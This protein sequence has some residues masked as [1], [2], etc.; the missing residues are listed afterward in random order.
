MKKISGRPNIFELATKE[1]TLDA[2]VAWL[3]KSSQSDRKPYQTMG[4]DFI[5]TFL[6]DG[7]VDGNDMELMDCRLQ[8]N[9]IDVFAVVR[10]GNVFHPVIFEDKTNTS[11][12]AGDSI[13]AGQMVSY[14]KKVLGWVETE[15][16]RKNEADGSDVLRQIA[17]NIEV[18][19]ADSVWGE[20]YYVYFKIGFIHSKDKQEYEAQ[21]EYLEKYKKYKSAIVFPEIRTLEMMHDFLKRHASRMTDDLLFKDY[22]AYVKKLFNEM[23]VSRTNWDADNPTKRKD[24]LH[25]YPGQHMVFEAAFGE[26]MVET[27]PGVP[28]GGLQQ[29]GHEVGLPRSMYFGGRVVTGK[30]KLHYIFTFKYL[31]REHKEYPVVSF[32]QYRDDSKYKAPDKDRIQEYLAVK[33]RVDVILEELLGKYH[34]NLRSSIEVEPEGGINKKLDSREYFRIVFYDDVR[35]SEI[36]K[37]IGDFAKQFAN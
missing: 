2:M 37:F 31:R 16:H 29:L 3:M 15:R 18:F 34:R 32:Q 13:G 26:D 20:I 1:L 11:L 12:H 19:D 6:F 14:C 33:K 36:S 7:M 22:H 17:E 30:K 25:Q 4:K 10:V 21:K 9:R 5:N 27:I 23:E 28:Y 8:Y 35:S 24:S